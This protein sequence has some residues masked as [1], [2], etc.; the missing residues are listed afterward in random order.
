MATVLV[1][2]DHPTSRFLLRSVLQLE[3]H[4]VLEALDGRAALSV[5]ALHPEVALLVTDLEMPGMG[6]LELLHSLASRTDL[7]KLIVSSCAT[8]PPLAELGVAGF[9]CKPPDLAQFKGAVAQLVGT[10]AT[11]T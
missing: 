4:T 7:P 6:G 10:P 3:G 1:V 9:F 2:D 5:L 8:E 11:P